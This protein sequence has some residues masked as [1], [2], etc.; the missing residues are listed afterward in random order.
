MPNNKE[1]DNQP[2]ALRNITNQPKSELKTAEPAVNSLASNMRTL[3][4][5][6]NDG[7]PESLRKAENRE[8]SSPVRGSGK[9]PKAEKTSQ[10]AV[11]REKEVDFSKWYRETLQKGGM[12]EPYEEVSGCFILKVNT[13]MNA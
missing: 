5:R 7:F 1:K 8:A 10:L 6:E 13:S 2:L 11:Q 9:R 3:N 12:L 4:M